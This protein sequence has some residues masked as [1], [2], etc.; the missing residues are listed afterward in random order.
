MDRGEKRGK[1]AREIRDSEFR[2]ELT[3]FE[4]Q[5]LRV[6]RETHTDKERGRK[7]RDTVNTY[8]PSECEKSSERRHRAAFCLFLQPK[9]HPSN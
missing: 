2:T 3:E 1:A 6:D 8:F 5:R 9:H 4:W 7:K